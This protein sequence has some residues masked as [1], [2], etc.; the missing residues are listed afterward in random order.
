MDVARTKCNEVSVVSAPARTGA[1]S[2]QLAAQ[3]GWRDPTGS[4]SF[5]FSFFFGMLFLKVI[6]FFNFT[7]KL[8]SHVLLI[9]Y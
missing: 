3:S 4:L 7:A 2:G 6:P 5:L 8:F 1:H 9:K